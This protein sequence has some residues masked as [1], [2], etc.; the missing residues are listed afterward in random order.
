M[1]A[2]FDSSVLLSLVL[3]DRHAARALA[4]WQETDRVSSLL[5]EIECRSVIR[6]ISGERQSAEAMRS[7]ER[8][9]EAALEEVTLKPLDEEIAEIVRSTPALAGCRSL[10]AVHLATAL[11]YRAGGGENLRVCTFDAKMA[12]I[13]AR[14]DLPAEGVE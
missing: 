1:P 7:A 5:L 13:A 2:Y 11:F 14:F 8:R 4:L 3:G 9:L 12:E 6:R 10:D